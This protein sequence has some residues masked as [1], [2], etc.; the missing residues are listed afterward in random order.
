MVDLV[1]V[2]GRS[3]QAHEVEHGRFTQT[4]SLLAGEEACVLDGDGCLDGKSL[5]QAGMLFVVVV[6]LGVVDGQHTDQPIADDERHAQP[7]M[8]VAV[9]SIAE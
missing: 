9:R 7:G 5:D 1:Q 2:D 4:L 6:W 3:C 8:N